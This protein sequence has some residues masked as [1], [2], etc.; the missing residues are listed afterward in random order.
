[1]TG[2]K[3]EGIR[4][5]RTQ[6]NPLEKR[7]ANEWRKRN[8]REGLSHGQLDYMLAEDPNKPGGE[9]TERDAMVAAAVVQWLGTHV[10]QC[11]LE[12]VQPKHRR[13]I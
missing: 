10:G 12:D 1:M 5:Q 2:I 9:V 4:A 3:H 7:F 6:H 13:D 11:F 8:K